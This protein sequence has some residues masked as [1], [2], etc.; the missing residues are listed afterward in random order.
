MTNPIKTWKQVI[1]TR[2]STGLVNFYIN[3]I[4]S[5]AANQVS[6]TPIA[7]TTNMFVGAYVPS[8]A[9]QLFKGQINQVRIIKGILNAQECQQLFDNERHDYGI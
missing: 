5:G 7:G 3:G 2:T 1:I 8:Y 4:L 9:D 6:G